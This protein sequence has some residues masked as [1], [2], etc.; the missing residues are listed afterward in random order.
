MALFLPIQQPT[1]KLKKIWLDFSANF[2]EN[3]RVPI[4]GIKPSSN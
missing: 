4:T 2:L 3:K 1:K